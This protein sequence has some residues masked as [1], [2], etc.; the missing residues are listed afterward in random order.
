MTD[1]LY[2]IVPPEPR[3]GTIAYLEDLLVR[4]KSGEI[5]SFGIVVQKSNGG[6]ANGWT[7][8]GT[9]CMSIIGELESMK[10]DIIH[11]KVD[12][13]YDCHGEDVLG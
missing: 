8:L 6:T 9:N 13:R 5:Q 3:P 2:K 4:A 11:A 1:N 7:G 10:L 12:Q